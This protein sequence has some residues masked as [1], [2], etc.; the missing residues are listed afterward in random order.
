MKSRKYSFTLN[1]MLIVV[2]I[3]GIFAAITVSNFLNTQVW[4]DKTVCSGWISLRFWWM[5]YVFHHTIL[6][7]PEF[8]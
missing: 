1:E 4:G 6:N 2:A 3:I 8:V 7:R 5:K